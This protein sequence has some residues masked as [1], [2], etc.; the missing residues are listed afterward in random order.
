LDFVAPD[1]VFVAPGF[2]FVAGGLAF[3]APDFD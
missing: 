3:V 2:D 1:L